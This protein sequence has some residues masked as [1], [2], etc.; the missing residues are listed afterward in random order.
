MSIWPIHIGS[1]STAATTSPTRNLG[2]ALM[3]TRIYAARVSCISTKICPEPKPAPTAGI[4]CPI[5]DGAFYAFFNV[6][7]HFGKTLKGKHI[8]DSTSFCAAALET[9]HVNLV[10]GS[11]FGAEGYVRLSFATSR[12][13]INQGI[14]RLAE[15]LA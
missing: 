13:Q 8:T 4:R 2:A 14:D 11:A 9:V 3:R 12:D 1:C 5:P 6:E 7:P 10:Q 15:F